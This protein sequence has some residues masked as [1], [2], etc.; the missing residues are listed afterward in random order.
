MLARFLET[1]AYDRSLRALRRAYQQQ[2]ERTADAVSRHFPEGTRITRPQGGV[3]L[4]LELPGKVDT[5]LLFE[6]AAEE[7]IAC[8]PG[9][10]FSPSGLYR[11]CLRLNCGNPWT[12]AIEAGVRRLGELA[13]QLPGKA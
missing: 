6:R 11:N 7:N 10:L 5:N 9:D 2:V 8:V 1:G 12:P 4:W 3:V 13:A